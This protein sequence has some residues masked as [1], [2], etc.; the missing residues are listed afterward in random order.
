MTHNW[1]R[2]CRVDAIEILEPE[3]EGW[4]AFR[5]T[6]R[7]LDRRGRANGPPRYMLVGGLPDWVDMTGL[8]VGVKAEFAYTAGP[9][10]TVFSTLHP[11][12]DGWR[13]TP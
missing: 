6:L 13:W 3:A 2:T 11:E 12:G 4:V 8:A 5:L 9:A 1:R 7:V 10:P